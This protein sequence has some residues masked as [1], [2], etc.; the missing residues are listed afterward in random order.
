MKWSKMIPIFRESSVV[1]KIRKNWRGA[2]W[3]RNITAE[4]ISDDL[5]C[6]RMPCK[7]VI[8]FISLVQ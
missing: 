7:N 6:Q 4:I 8:A 5:R 2:S 1:T 3:A